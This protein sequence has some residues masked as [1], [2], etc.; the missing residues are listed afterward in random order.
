VISWSIL[1]LTMAAG[2][3]FTK[4]GLRYIIIPAAVGFV[5]CAGSL[6]LQWSEPVSSDRGVIVVAGTQLHVGNGDGFALAGEAS[7]DMGTMFEVV[8]QRGDWLQ[9]RT[10]DGR[11]GWLTKKNTEL[12]SSRYW[13]AT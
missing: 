13:H 4:K 1:W 2:L 11:A 6:G 3:L 5:L 9:I 8:Q 12:I 7:L 10:P